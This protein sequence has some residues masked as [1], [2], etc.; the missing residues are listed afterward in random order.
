MFIEP[1]NK[2]RIHRSVLNDALFID[3][4]MFCEDL[5]KAH[6]LWLQKVS[7]T[8]IFQINIDKFIQRYPDGLSPYIT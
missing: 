7:S 4:E 5:I 1:G 6:K 3:I 8:K 2:I